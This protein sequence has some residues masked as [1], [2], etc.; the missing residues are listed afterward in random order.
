[1]AISI[2]NSTPNLVYVA[3]AYYNEG[4]S[5]RYGKRGWYSIEPGR[6]TVVFGGRSNHAYFRFY[7]E[8]NFGHVWGG[9]DFTNVPNEAFDMCW[10]ANCIPCR[11]L[12]FRNPGYF[13][14]VFCP[15]DRLI[16]LVLSSS[17]RQSKSSKIL[18]AL[19]TK[20]KL[21]YRKYPHGIIKKTKSQTISKSGN[22]RK[23]IPTKRKLK[24]GAN[25]MILKRRFEGRKK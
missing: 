7:A 11:R 18:I 9:D 20:R 12:G 21:K 5:P 23:A 13:D 24:S 4:C 19:P 8:D 1:M 6:T 2:R 3:V 15:G 16:N 14:C 25:R 22:V 10:V 17:R